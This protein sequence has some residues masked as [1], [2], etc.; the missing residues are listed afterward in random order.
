[1]TASSHQPRLRVLILSDGIPG[2][3]NQALG[4]AALLN[5]VYQ[6]EVELHQTR[7]RRKW[8]RPLL[9][10][11]CNH[12]PNPRTNRWI[13]SRYD[14]DYTGNTPDL[15]ISAGGNTAFLNI[16][17]SRRFDCPN[18]FLGSLRGLHG[19]LFSALFTLERQAPG[20]SNI[21]LD[22]VPTG[23][24][25]ASAKAA[26]EARFRDPPT[27]L[28]AMLIGGDGA[29]YHYDEA[30]WLALARGMKACQAQFGIR[31]LITS[32]RRT[33]LQNETRLRS[34]VD[35]DDLFETTWYGQNAESVSQAYMG[36]ADR[37]FCTEDSM[38]M[39]QESIATGRS[40]TSLHPGLARPTPRYRDAIKSLQNKGLINRLPLSRFAQGQCPAPESSLPADWQAKLLPTILARLNAT[41]P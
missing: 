9:R 21:V 25:P 19:T 24:T 34:L 39:L 29:G 7:L 14:S 28:W 6:V 3:E 38:T 13:S 27:P 22:V 37:I 15:I 33:G 20:P 26:A 30:D 10:L 12:L 41:Q 40:V 16:A 1:M 36:A 35:S 18:F 31:W 17:L 32:S 23:V 4:L 5:D 8:L 2:H 11:L